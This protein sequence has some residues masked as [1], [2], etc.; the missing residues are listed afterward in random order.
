MNPRLVVIT[1]Q[2]KGQ[3]ITLMEET[4]IGSSLSNQLEQGAD[5]RSLDVSP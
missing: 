2:L 5:S 1:G 4:F 3:V